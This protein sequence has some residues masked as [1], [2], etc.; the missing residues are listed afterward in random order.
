M[1][2]P[3]AVGLGVAGNQISKKV[4]GSSEVSAGRTVVA[5]GAGAA[6]GAAAAGTLV[7][8]GVAAAAP[9]T[10]PLAIAAGAVSFVASL[11]D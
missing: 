4:T 2:I 8:A 9:I 7:I 11:F 3:Q 1:A 5:T 6:L 10:V